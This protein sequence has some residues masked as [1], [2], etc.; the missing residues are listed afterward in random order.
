[1]PLTCS[2][3]Y[4]NKPNRCAWICLSNPIDSTKNIDTKGFQSS[5]LIA[6][7]KNMK[8]CQKIAWKCFPPDAFPQI[9]IHLSWHRYIQK[10]GKVVG[11]FSLSVRMNTLC[12]K[13]SPKRG[14]SCSLWAARHCF[15]WK[16]DVG[17][18]V[19]VTPP[20]LQHSESSCLQKHNLDLFA[21][22]HKLHF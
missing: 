12:Q 21:E 19:G 3:L 8:F 11:L 6:I 20:S 4:L 15:T 9:L 18:C 16:R 14:A 10:K 1:M 22:I 17:N 7:F 2:S 5:H 13:C